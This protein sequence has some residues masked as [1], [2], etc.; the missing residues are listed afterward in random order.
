MLF[1]FSQKPKRP[2]YVFRIF[3]IIAYGQ[4]CIDLHPFWRGQEL[5]RKDPEHSVKIVLLC[6]LWKTEVQV[7]K[8]WKSHYLFVCH[9]LLHLLSTVTADDVWD[10]LQSLSGVI[11]ELLLKGPF[12]RAVGPGEPFIQVEQ[13]VETHR[14]YN[15]PPAHRTPHLSKNGIAKLFYSNVY[16]I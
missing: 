1:C 13:T 6:F 12:F 2:G 4:L 15:N 11:H 5:D 14:E 7:S 9:S 8:W 3:E 16:S 10:G